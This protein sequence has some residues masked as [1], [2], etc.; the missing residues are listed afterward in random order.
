MV[1]SLIDIKQFL[2]RYVVRIQR[3]LSSCHPSTR[4][5]DGHPLAKKFAAR[6]F[7]FFLQSTGEVD[8]ESGPG[9]LPG[10][11]GTDGSATQ[12]V[13]VNMEHLLTT[14][15]IGIDDGAISR[16]IDVKKTRNMGR[17]FQE[18]SEF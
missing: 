17:P 18:I 16:L 9:W 13:G 15:R 5:L 6:L 3:E 7:G 4:P 8:D 10:H 12:N 11:H 2:C 1:T 14:M